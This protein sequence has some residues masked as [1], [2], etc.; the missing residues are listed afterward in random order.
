MGSRKSCTHACT[1][2]VAPVV[3]AVGTRATDGSVRSVF[4]SF[5]SRFSFAKDARRDC[6]E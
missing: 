2:H 5:G 6:E 4:R 1:M 3:D